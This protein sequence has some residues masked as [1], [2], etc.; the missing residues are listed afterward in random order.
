[1]RFASSHEGVRL[2]DLGQMPASALWPELTGH[3]NAKVRRF[4]EQ[5]VPRWERQVIARLKKRRTLKRLV[6]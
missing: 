6:K 2:I 1:M 4:A 3:P 5:R